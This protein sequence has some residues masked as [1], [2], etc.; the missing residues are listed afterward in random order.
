VGAEFEST[1]TV[2]VDVAFTLHC[3]HHIQHVPPN[4][5]QST[6]FTP[7][8]CPSPLLRDV[9]TTINASSIQPHPHLPF[10]ES[11]RDVGGAISLDKGIW[12]GVWEGDKYQGGPKN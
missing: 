12:E 4:S 10:P 7:A 8:I 2:S 9:G 6:N 11:Q 3:S 5:P 1:S